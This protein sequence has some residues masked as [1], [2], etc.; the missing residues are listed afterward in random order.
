MA[1]KLMTRETTCFLS[2]LFVIVDFVPCLGQIFLYC[3]QRLSLIESDLH[4]TEASANT[5]K[6]V[7]L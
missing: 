3:V 6:I 2:D 5:L 7:C 1:A 4:S